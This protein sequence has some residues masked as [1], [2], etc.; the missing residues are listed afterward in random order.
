MKEKVA[1]LIQK[2]VATFGCNLLCVK[3]WNEL[4]AETLAQG[5]YHVLC[6]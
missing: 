3:V 5:L 6:H 4:L 2:Q 1:V